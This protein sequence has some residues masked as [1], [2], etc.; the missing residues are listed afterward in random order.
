MESMM[1]EMNRMIDID[2]YERHTPTPWTVNVHTIGK[3]REITA[4]VIESNMTTHSNCVLAEVEVENKYAE[5]DAQLIADAPLILQALIDERAEVKRLRE[6]E[7]RIRT[8]FGDEEM[9]DFYDWMK[10]KYGDDEE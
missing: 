5:A 1:M 7:N 3:D 8:Y 6:W 2:K 10:K 9:M 4:I